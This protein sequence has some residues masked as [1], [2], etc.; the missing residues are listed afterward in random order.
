M[1]VELCPTLEISG[2]RN[3]QDGL[4]K[5]IKSSALRLALHESKMSG[6]HLVTVSPGEVLHTDVLVGVLGTL[7]E[8]GH[9]RPV[10]P[11]LSPKVVGV[12]TSGNQDRNDGAAKK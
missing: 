11:V 5:E 2:V 6:T 12:D 4:E 3:L 10:F 9:V 8:R 1:T 7:L